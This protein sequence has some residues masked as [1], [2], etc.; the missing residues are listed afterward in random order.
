[1]TKKRRQK[2]QPKRKR[3]KPTTTSMSS[4]P[5][6]TFGP[7][8]PPEISQ[9]D[10]GRFIREMS[11]RALA[12]FPHLLERL[13]AQMAALDP[14]LLLTTLGR[15]SMVIPLG[16]M[17][18]EELS[19]SPAFQP[20][21]ELLQAMALRRAYRAGPPAL[22]ADAME[23][24]AAVLE[25]L[26]RAFAMKRMATLDPGAPDE[27]RHRSMVLE[28]LRVQTQAIRNWSYPQQVRRTIT[29][30]FRPIDDT[31]LER[32]GVRVS[33]LA[34]MWD[35]A[36]ELFEQRF[37]TVLSSLRPVFEA[38]RVEAAVKAYCEA[39]PDIKTPPAALL[40]TFREVGASLDQAKQLL[41]AH[42]NLRLV[43]IHRFTVADWS[44]CYPGDV[45]PAVLQRV[46]DQWS[47]AF[48]DLAE[49][50]PEHFFMNNPVWTR[51]LI[52]V[53]AGDY[54]CPHLG[55]STSFAMELMEHILAGDSD[56]L[57]RYADRRAKYLEERVAELMG[58]AVPGATIHRDVLWPDPDQPSTI[59]ENDIL[60]VI[61]SL[62]L[63]VECKAGRLT[64]PARRGGEARVEH[65]VEELIAGP[66]RQAKRFEDF[67]RA[68]P[69]PHLFRTK[70]GE[71]VRIDTAALSEIAS[72]SITL[73]QLGTLGARWTALREAGFIEE[74]EEAAPTIALS[75]L[76][77]ILEILETPAE[78]LH[79]LSR[80]ADFERA[81]T[82]TGD[83]LDLLAFY[84]HTGFNLRGV[85]V[86]DTNVMIW[87]M[88]RELDPYFMQE[89]VHRGRS[90]VRKP[91]RTLT[92]WWREILAQLDARHT[93]GWLAI[94]LILLDFP[95]DAQTSFEDT[96]RRSTTRLKREWFTIPEG[97]ITFAMSG[98]V[99][100][101]R[102]GVG[103]LL[104]RRL[105]R[106]ERHERVRRALGR[107]GD[108]TNTDHIVLIGQDVI[109]PAYP[110]GLIATPDRGGLKED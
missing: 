10:I 30:L 110:Y 104:F 85:N 98:N 86:E 29:D 109:Q 3:R 42:V 108:M 41:A 16:T 33:N 54:V 51:P 5:L 64:A 38:T 74:T 55:L 36:A 21:V 35:K 40:D 89:S 50:N 25:E 48:G 73:D 15:Q 59:W 4:R 11:A 53:G 106:D 43:E 105:T 6:V 57:K 31:I 91:R 24:L 82:Y 18:P 2:R 20:H 1:M 26:S 75:D 92:K 102:S 14:V 96:F 34:E 23:T 84:L 8:V 100:G 13:D 94:S 69:G 28:G 70:A 76:E 52:R 9:E 68:H 97:Q 88:S 101:R 87:N 27:A 17:P 37:N 49:A 93:P 56:L 32:L 99:G 63:I 107:L 61:D 65:S 67:L 83:E 62:L 95:I 7:M 47:H 72:V 44:G 22:A 39:F 81:T 79:Y 19:T 12:D 58:Q 66:A 103:A 71:E 78:R 46:L 60:V 77:V 90:R 45:E 80:R